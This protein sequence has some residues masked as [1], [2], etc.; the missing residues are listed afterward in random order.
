MH[1]TSH[2]SFIRSTSELP[3]AICISA[4]E[5]KGSSEGIQFGGSSF[6]DSVDQPVS[7]YNFVKNIYYYT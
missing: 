1:M 5:G 3:A 7:G 2:L 4:P 6:S